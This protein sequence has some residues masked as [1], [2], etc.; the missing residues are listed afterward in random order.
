MSTIIGV[1]QGAVLSPL[2]FNVYIDD[3]LR[4]LRQQNVQVYAYADDIAF[5]SDNAA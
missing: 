1:P 2:L 3:L 4:Q 5:T